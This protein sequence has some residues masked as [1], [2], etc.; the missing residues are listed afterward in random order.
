MACSAEIAPDSSDQAEEE[1]SSEEAQTAAVRAIPRVLPFPAI[2]QGTTAGSAECKARCQALI[3][4]Y[5]DV[6]EDAQCTDADKNNCPILRAK[7]LSHMAC[8]Q[9]RNEFKFF[10]PKA[11]GFTPDKGHQS[12]IDRAVDSANQCAVMFNNKPKCLKSNGDQKLGVPPGLTP[13]GESARLKCGYCQRRA[14][15]RRRLWVDRP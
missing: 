8:A 1:P 2:G 3:D 15:A 11:M 13:A 14:A 7:F 10:C 9:A 6:C 12:A 4:Y 5:K